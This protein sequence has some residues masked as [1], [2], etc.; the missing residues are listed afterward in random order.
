MV[1]NSLEGA[2]FGGEG[3]VGEAGY[4]SGKGEGVY[5]SGE[6]IAAGVGVGHKIGADR[7]AIAIAVRYLGHLVEGINSAVCEQSAG[8]DFPN[9]GSQL[10]KIP[11]RII[12]MHI[13]ERVAIWETRLNLPTERVREKGPRAVVGMRRSFHKKF[14]VPRFICHHWL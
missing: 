2:Y 10:G 7:G 14:N 6:G 11:S 5:Y 12:L 1:P 3:I 4:S 13:G 9:V 8:V